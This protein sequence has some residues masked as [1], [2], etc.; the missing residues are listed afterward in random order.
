MNYLSGLSLDLGILGGLATDLSY[1]N[2]RDKLKYQFRYQK[3]MSKTQTYFTSGISFYHYLNNF[4][5]KDNVKRNYSVS[6]S[7]NINDLGYLSFQYHEKTYE[8]TSK[9]FELG[10]SFSSSINK[11][12]YN[13]KY[14]FKKNKSIF[15]HSFSLNLHMPLGNNSDHYHWFN[16]QTNYQNKKKHYINTTNIGGTLLNYNLGY[17][18]NYQHT[19][20][21]KRKSNHFSTNARYQNNYQSYTFNMNKMEDSY[22]YNVSINGG[23]V[24][25]SNGI[26][27]TPRLGRTFALIN[28]QGISG[29]KT[30]FSTKAK[31]DI[32]GN[33][34]LNNITPYRINNIKL[35]ATT[36]PQQAE[37]EIYSKNIIPTLGAVSKIT[38]PIK[39]GYRVIFKSTT[40]LPFA[41]TVTTFDK[42]GNIISHGLVSENNIIFLSGITEN[43]LVKVKWGEDK[44][45]QFNYEIDDNEKNTTLIKKEINCI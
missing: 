40:P 6:V 11:I 34:I 17:S 29:I 45:C 1:E 36:L 33:L 28:T 10:T 15:D 22:N 9:N 24:F 35:N 25:H 18:V 21:E 13:L 37:T 23:F 19:Y 12:N 44:Q 8:N 7:Q 32:F 3:S 16:N 38:F 5:K 43:G 27:L 2:S 20:D 41:S 26:T 14:D 42:N 30:S 31:T 4:Q 39:I